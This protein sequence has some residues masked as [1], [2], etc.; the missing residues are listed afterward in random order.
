MATG[1]DIDMD[2]DLGPIEDHAM[3]EDQAVC[4]YQRFRPT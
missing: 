1:M 3:F 4:F 2:L